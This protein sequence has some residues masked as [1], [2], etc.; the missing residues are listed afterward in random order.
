M[1]VR[2]KCLSPKKNNTLFQ[3]LYAGAHKSYAKAPEHL[4]LCVNSEWSGFGAAP[5]FVAK[6]AFELFASPGNSHRKPLGY[7]Y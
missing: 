6:S 7:L 3:D 2:M 4:I 5:N 1:T